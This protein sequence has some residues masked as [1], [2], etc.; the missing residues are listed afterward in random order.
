MCPTVKT[1]MMITSTP[2][3]SL[4][5][6]ESPSPSPRIKELG[7]RLNSGGAP[8]L[9]AVASLQEPI[10]QVAIGPSHIAVLT[11]SGAVGRFVFSV[12]IDA[13]DL[14]KPDSN[15]GWDACFIASCVRS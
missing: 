13:L 11:E 15:K 1:C 14:N 7:A 4:F 12:N 5:T 8:G 2:A 10:K 6:Q 9:S 3:P